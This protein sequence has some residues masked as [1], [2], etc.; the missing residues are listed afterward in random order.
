LA[1]SVFCALIQEYERLLG[2]KVKYYLLVL[3][4]I[5]EFHINIVIRQVVIYY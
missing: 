4:E 2:C 1:C 3:K 5:L